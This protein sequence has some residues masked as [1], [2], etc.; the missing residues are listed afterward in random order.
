MKVLIVIFWGLLQHDFSV[1]AASDSQRVFEPGQNAPLPGTNASSALY[2]NPA[3]PVASRVADLLSRMTIVDKTAQLMQGGM[4]SWIDVK[5]GAF[6]SSGLAKSMRTK[7][8][9]FYV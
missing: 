9:Q 2:R 1:L 3:A 8:S 4:D 6:N 7:A 5:T